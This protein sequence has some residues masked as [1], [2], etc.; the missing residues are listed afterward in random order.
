MWELWI[1]TGNAT[2][3]IERREYF[4]TVEGAAD[5]RT[6]LKSIEPFGSSNDYRIA[7]VDRQVSPALRSVRTY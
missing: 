2:Q 3:T 6:F 5:R 4:G 1:E 7:K